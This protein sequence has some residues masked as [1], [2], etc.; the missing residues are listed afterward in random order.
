[1][2]HET[3]FK[4]L[5][6]QLGLIS[7]E[8]HILKCKGRLGNAP[9]NPTTPPPYPVTKTTSCDK[10]DRGSLPQKGEAWGSEGT[11]VELRTEYWIPKG[12][13]LVKKILHHCVTCKKLGGAPFRPQPS[14]NLP[15][16]RVTGNPAF[17][18][19]GVDFAGPLFMKNHWRHEKPDEESIH[20]PIHMCH[21][22]SATPGT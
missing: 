17:T 14:A 10:I 8:E 19:V 1:M 4:I 7:D 18:H 13:Q 6:Q 2:K 12:R 11:L 20:L 5:K 9:L 22:K 16:T 15:K 3:S 21:I